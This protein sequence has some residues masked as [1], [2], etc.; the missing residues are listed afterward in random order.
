MRKMCII[1]HGKFADG[2]Q[3]S[4]S[5]FLGEDHHFDE[6]SAYVNDDI[7]PKTQIDDYMKRINDDDQLIFLTDIMGGSVNTLVMPYLSRPNTF[8]IAGINFPLL[9]QLSALP[10]DADLNSFKNLVENCRKSIVLMNDIDYTQ[11]INE[12]DE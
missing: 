4:L 3:Q 10:E 12:D 11:F 8:I 5:I 1:T 7:Q 9:L 6:I 2:I